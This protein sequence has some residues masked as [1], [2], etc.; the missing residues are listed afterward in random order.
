MFHLY[1]AGMVNFLAASLL[2]LHLMLPTIH[3]GCQPFSVVQYYMTEFSFSVWLWIAKFLLQLNSIHFKFPLWA[4]SLL[5]E[6]DVLLMGQHC[7]IH[8]LKMNKV[9]AAEHLLH[10][11]SVLQEFHL[12]GYDD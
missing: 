1:I 10:S 4:I 12:S 6:Q 5:D 7:S 9:H 2:Y 3:K 11:S 8:P